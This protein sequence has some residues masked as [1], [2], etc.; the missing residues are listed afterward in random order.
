MHLSG[1]AL[2]ADKARWLAELSAAL[3]EA[4]ILVKE[5]GAADGRMEAVE[6]YAQIEALRLE[7]E[8]MRLRRPSRS[9]TEI[10]PEWS[11]LPWVRRPDSTTAADPPARSGADR[12][13]PA[14]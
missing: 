5:L 7:V 3:R 2:A 10:G 13:V 14:A 8:S 6:L 9:D 1:E 4:R 12:E 11:E